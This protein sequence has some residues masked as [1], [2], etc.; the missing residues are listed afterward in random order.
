MQLHLY[1]AT[2]AGSNS[3]SS[4]QKPTSNWKDEEEDEIGHRGHSEVW[5]K[6]IET[7]VVRLPFARFPE[8]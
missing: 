7:G 5:Q 3:F 4:T 2:T 6:L 8:I 1:T